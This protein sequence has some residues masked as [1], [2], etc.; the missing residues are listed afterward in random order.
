V[1]LLL[2]PPAAHAQD[3]APADDG[4]R[5][6][7]VV[8]FYGHVF[9]VG[10]DDPM[11]ANTYPPEGDQLFASGYA[12][13]NCGVLPAEDPSGIAAP[14]GT[15]C[16]TDP[17]DKRVLFLTA[18]PVQ[19]H[20]TEDFNYTAL[21]NE[22]GRAK[23][24]YLDTTKDVHAWFYAAAD[25]HSWGL[26]CGGG[27]VVGIPQPGP[28][29]PCPLP[30]WSWDPGV[31]PNFVVEGTLYMAELGD[32]G[33]GASDPPPIHDALI[34]GKAKAI[35]HGATEP[36][37]LQTG[38]PG[39]P[40]SVEFDVNLGKPAMDVIPKDQDVFLVLS[41]YEAVNGQKMSLGGEF[42][43][44]VKPWAGEQ[45]P[46]RFTLPVKNPFD[47]ELVIPQFVH[48]KV[49]VHGV[50]SSPWG[51]YDVD[52]K[53]VTLELRDGNGQFVQAQHITRS[54]DYSVAHGA[55]F[56]PVN[57]TWVWD[58]KADGARP[59]TYK[60]LVT[61]CDLEH[62]CSATE[63]TF[64]INPDGSAG[65]YTVGRSGQL[66]ASQGQLSA[67]TGAPQPEGGVRVASQD[68]KATPGVEALGVLAALGIALLARRR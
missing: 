19:I 64:T 20:R 35:A 39:S 50:L 5:A 60:A 61:G 52:T 30:F 22:H 15:S 33:Q 49:L 54:G 65:T 46:N 18:G 68:A 16:D 34:A 59:G 13:D 42:A 48:D 47:V 14:G 29:A 4:A 9:S 1:S 7:Q 40:N 63:A 51:S 44:S 67:L 25:F 8:T 28:D 66:T 31:M 41:W 21:H 32:Y 53:G 36:V 23:D 2:L 45:F 11:P 27:I 17:L 57:L 12:P 38:L 24:V 62:I 58:Y 43:P 6:S 10:L 3:A 55:H 37:Q 26:F 56:K